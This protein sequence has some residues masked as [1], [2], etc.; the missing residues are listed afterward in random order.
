ML[1][2]IKS[3]LKADQGAITVDW[4]VL[5]ATIVGLAG[6]SA[7]LVNDGIVSAASHIEDGIVAQDVG[8]VN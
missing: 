4:V 3:F 2:R 7:L 6:T 1:K 8:V 5:T